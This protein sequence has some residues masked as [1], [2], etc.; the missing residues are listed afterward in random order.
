[1]IFKKSNKRK[2]AT[3]DKSMQIPIPLA[4]HVNLVAVMLI[5]IERKDGEDSVTIFAPPFIGNCFPIVSGG[6]ASQYLS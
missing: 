5:W 4:S 1:M 2:K 3:F 6:V